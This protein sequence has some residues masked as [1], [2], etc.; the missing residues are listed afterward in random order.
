MLDWS[1]TWFARL[2]ML[3]LLLFPLGYAYFSFARPGLDSR[4]WAGPLALVTLSVAA[5][6]PS[7]PLLSVVEGSDRVAEAYLVRLV[8]YV[9]GACLAWGLLVAGHGLFAPAMAPLAT[10]VVVQVW[11]RLRYP[12]LVWHGDLPAFPW[13]EQVLPL[14]RKVALSCVA[15]YLFLNAP[16]LI[17]FYLSDAVSAGRL[18]LSMVI[19]NVVG[20]LS[21]SWLSAKLARI[22]QLVV[23]EG[24]A[25]ARAVFAS[26]FRLALLLMAAAYALT[27]AVLWLVREV[28]L[29]QR[30]LAP[31]DIAL[32][33]FVFS[34]FHTAGM[35][36]VY[37]RA[38]GEEF[39][40]SPLI[41]ATGLAVLSSAF[42]ASEHGVQGVLRSFAIMYVPVT[43]I[44][45][46]LSW[47]HLHRQ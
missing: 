44:A 23:T 47:R 37:F 46:S 7:Y 6:M 20:A 10:A 14:Q 42:F 17:V 12:A 8:C 45:G 5:S 19:A 29:A 33:F 11:A 32:L 43:I 15:S 31:S 16:T 30:L 25:A 3:T 40:A 22:A 41:I 38:R 18:G 1:R 28:P 2:G 39:I 21:A 35:V 27:F 34:M 26:A 9:I 24:T 36:G 13:R 4:S